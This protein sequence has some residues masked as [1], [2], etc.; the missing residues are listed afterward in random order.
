MTTTLRKKAT[1]RDN[2][3]KPQSSFDRLCQQVS[4]LHEEIM[5]PPGQ[6]GL[7][8]KVESHGNQLKNQ[9]TI[10]ALTGA[11]LLGGMVKVF[12]F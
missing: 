10:L 6:P 7:K 4:D 9:W 1:A 2:P 3:E 12:F 8:G 11:A 5:G